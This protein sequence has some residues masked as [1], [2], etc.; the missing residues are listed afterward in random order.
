MALV[1]PAAQALGLNLAM[2]DIAGDDALEAR[3]GTSIP[4]LSCSDGS[5][6]CWPFDN[7]KVIEFLH[8]HKE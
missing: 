8:S 6:L 1:L 4:V 2:T 3:Y 5:E 7:D